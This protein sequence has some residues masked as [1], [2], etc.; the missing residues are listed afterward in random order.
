MRIKYYCIVEGL[1][2]GRKC[3]KVANGRRSG[4]GDDEEFALVLVVLLGRFVE[5]TKPN[6]ADYRVERRRK[7]KL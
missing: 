7:K 5:T 3:V 2:S 6:Y 4:G 1:G